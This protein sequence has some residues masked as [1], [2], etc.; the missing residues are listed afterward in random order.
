MPKFY[1]QNKKRI[2][3]RY[4]LEETAYSR[5]DDEDLK[6]QGVTIGGKWPTG[7]RNSPGTSDPAARAA[8]L[9][10]QGMEQARTGEKPPWE[11]PDSGNLGLFDGTMEDGTPVSAVLNSVRKQLNIPGGTAILQKFDQLLKELGVD[12]GE[13][14]SASGHEG[15][16]PG[17]DEMEDSLKRTQAS[18]TDKEFG[19]KRDWPPGY[20]E[21]S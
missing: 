8:E 20:E 21:Y 13:P 11:A 19:E 17:A 1:K 18:L 14:P 7:H 15:F 3:P 4:F 16:D 2:D 6:R 5:D 12:L 10:Q 9:A